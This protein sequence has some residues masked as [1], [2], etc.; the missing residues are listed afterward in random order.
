MD[1]NNKKKKHFRIRE[2]SLCGSAD[3][4]FH[5]AFYYRPVWSV[6]LGFNFEIFNNFVSFVLSDCNQSQFEIRMYLLT[7]EVDNAKKCHVNLTIYFWFH[8]QHHELFEKCYFWRWFWSVIPN[9]CSLII[10]ENSANKWH[11]EHTS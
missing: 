1:S 3:E 9:G 8:Q 10:I 5:H 11:L 7:Y 2:N 4:F 6:A